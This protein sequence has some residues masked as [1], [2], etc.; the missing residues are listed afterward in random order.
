MGMEVLMP[1]LGMT[2]EEGTIV[3][4]FKGV[5]DLVQKGEPL[6]EILT[7]KVNM[8]VE[9]PVSGQILAILA[10]DGELLPVNV[11]IAY[12]GQPGENT[13]QPP[14]QRRSPNKLPIT[15]RPKRQH[16]TSLSWL[17]AAG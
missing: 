8:E 7:D 1:K 13:N 17:R 9:S 6:V 4:W 14:P 11:P 2:M 12:I 5:G 15:W 3:R 10:G 16:S